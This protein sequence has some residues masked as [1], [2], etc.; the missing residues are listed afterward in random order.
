MPY[1][2]YLFCEKCGPPANVVLDY[3]NTINE[4]IKD[5]RK[6]TSIDDRNLMWDYLVY[7]CP[8]C[9]K[10]YKY[11][12]QDVELRVR[13]YFASQAANQVEFLESVAEPL[14]EKHKVRKRVKEMY[15]A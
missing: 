13:T 12:F 2:N 10:Q 15:G 9:G 6:N 11:T 1:T 8:R 4:Y 3:I 5:G 7:K 14:P